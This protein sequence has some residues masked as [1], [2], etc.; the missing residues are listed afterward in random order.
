MNISRLQNSPSFT[1]HCP[2][3]RLGLDVCNVITKEFPHYSLT[4]L[5][6]LINRN[7]RTGKQAVAYQKLIMKLNKYRPRITN[8]YL[9]YLNS[10]FEYIKNFKSFNC[11]ESGILGDFVLKLNG[12][13]NSYIAHIY[14]GSFNEEH[15]V[16]F[17]NR[18]GSEY[19]GNIKNNQTIIVDP[20]LCICGFANDIFKE[21]DQGVWSEYFK[22]PKTFADSAKGAYNF[23]YVEK[24][25]L[26]DEYLN[27]I[28]ENFPKLILKNY[29]QK[30]K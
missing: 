22:V 7:M 29:E 23:K 3:V 27:I 6:P 10:L 16:S 2:D 1:S 19:D 21:F 20:W 18:D 9:V 11:N 14:K 17:F 28:K 25:D 8:D 24:I 4:K 5:E 12:I 15:V 13:K 30:K 26:P